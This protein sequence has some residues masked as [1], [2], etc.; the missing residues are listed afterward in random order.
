M[1]Q[2][3][4]DEKYER[5]LLDYFNENLPVKIYDA[6]FHIS[7]DYA[8]RSGYKGEPFKQFVEFT[9]KYTVRSFT[10]GLVMPQ[11]ST[12]H[13]KDT[14]ADD[15]AYNL[16]LAQKY[17]LEAGLIVTPKC[18]CNAITAMLDK[19]PRVKVLKPYLTYT[20]DTKMFETDILSFA[21]EWIWELAN[22]RNMPIML[23]LSHYQNMLNEESNWRQIRTLSLKYP[24]VK[25]I[26]AHCAMGHHVR[27][28]RLGLEH[29]ND[30]KN[31]WFDCSGTAETMSIYYCIKYFGVEKMMYG[32]DFNH[33]ANVGRI[34]S[35]GSNFIGFHEAYININNIPGDYKYQPL[36]NALECML[37]LI[38]ACELL[39][40]SKK[41]IEDI[42]Y[43][44]AV[45]LFGKNK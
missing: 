38:E 10:G 28:L 27:K 34:C 31:I 8:K 22:G 4:Y 37:A 23:H 13:T 1:S 25:L 29:I 16:A 12:R 2:I 32:G 42:F 17:D 7:R 18:S 36:N 24:K 3:V 15:N 40:L 14:L 5:D 43:N 30:L 19:H 45:K 9:E 26:L 21:P 20:S 33:G 39:A 44:N 6:H 11:P 41:E 35:F